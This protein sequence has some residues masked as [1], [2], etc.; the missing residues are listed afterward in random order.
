MG[1]ECIMTKKHNMLIFLL[2]TILY[3]AYK[4]SRAAL[5]FLLSLTFLILYYFHFFEKIFN[6]PLTFYYYLC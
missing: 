6:L 2:T 3:I 4:D 5:I 1:Y